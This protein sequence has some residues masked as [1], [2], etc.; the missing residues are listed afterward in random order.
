VNTNGLRGFKCLSNS[1]K[2]GTQIKL[3][4][5][6]EKLKRKFAVFG[7]SGVTPISTRSATIDMAV[8]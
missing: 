5:L 8:K 3:T 4:P 1:T 6:K 2:W 7:R